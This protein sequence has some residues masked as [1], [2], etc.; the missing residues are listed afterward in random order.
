MQPDVIGLLHMWL[1][2][3]YSAVKV[4]TKQDLAITIAHRRSKARAREREKAAWKL[5][6][7]YW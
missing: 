3:E 2:G 6:R 4:Y 5:Q 7:R 1:G